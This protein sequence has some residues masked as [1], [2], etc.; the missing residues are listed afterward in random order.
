MS[1]DIKRFVNLHKLF[2][3][4][5]EY[6]NLHNLFNPHPKYDALQQDIDECCEIA[7]RYNL[8]V[9]KEEGQLKGGR[10]IYQDSTLYELRVARLF[11]NYFRKGCLKWDQPS[12]TDR[13]VE[14]LLNIDN[15]D[16]TQCSIFTEVKTIVK[17]EYTEC[18]TLRSKENS[19]ENALKKA[20]EKI[21]NGIDIPFLT[22][23]CHNH[24]E[25][26]IS[27][28]EIVRVMFG[29]ISYQGGVQEVIARGFCSPDIHRKLSAVGLYSFYSNYYS[30][31][32]FQLFHNE[33]ANNPIERHRFDKKANQQFYLSEWSGKFNQCP[34]NHLKS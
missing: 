8:V 26:E 22:V 2:D 25:I 20:Y 33:N 14:F 12:Q 34:T 29:D 1:S 11:E 24:F 21:A 9:D 19:I 5:K 13:I 10:S 31:E 30:P 3:K 27:K 15:P 6:H 18:G 16:G 32:V 23:L 28:F 7:L 17:Q 4:R